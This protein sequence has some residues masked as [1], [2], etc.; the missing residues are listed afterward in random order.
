MRTPWVR[1]M[2][3]ALDDLETWKV[4]NMK[5]SQTAWTDGVIVNYILKRIDLDPCGIIAMFAKESAADEFVEEKF[6]PAVNATPRMAGKIEVNT[7]RKAGN[8]KLFKKYPGGFLKLV[9][10]NSPSSV[11]S[12]SAPVSIV[13]E[14]DDANTNVKGQGDTIKLLEDRSKTY[15]DRLVIYGGTPTIEGLSAIQDAYKSSDQRMYF[16]PC[17]ACGES[18]VLDWTNVKWDDD[19][20]IT[21][22]VYGHA[23]P[24][25]AFY[26]CPACGVIWDDD[27]KNANV[28]AAES[29]DG[30]GWIATVE[31]RGIA[32]FGYI[33]EL[34][35]PFDASRFKYLVERY[36]EAEN[37]EKQGDD[38]DM[39]AFVNTCLGKPYE[40]KNDNLNAEG[41]ETRAEDYE[42]ML[43]QQGG[44]VVTAGVDVQHDRFA[45]ILRA[46]GRG[47]ESW[48]VYWGE[49]FGVVTDKKD[50]V[51]TELERLLFM[52]PI[53]HVDGFN[54]NVSALSIDTSDGTTS[55][56]VYD[57]VRRMKRKYARIKTIP[58]KGSSDQADKEIF[59][60]PRISVDHRTPTKASRYGLRIFMVG[61]NKA[62]DL[63]TGR[64]QLTGAGPGRVHFYK[65]VRADYYAQITSEVKAPS[66]RLRGRMVWQKKSGVR[67][68][69]FDCE[70]Y[71][72]HAARHERVHLMTPA[73]WDDLEH[74][75]KQEDLFSQASVAES[76]T[77]M[78][79]DNTETLS[80]ITESGDPWLS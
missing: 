5:A 27:Q 3:A 8:K 12:T 17:H 43:V 22:E 44:L 40:Y 19:P 75:L 71:T 37:K 24:E 14:P 25:T 67:N 49:I 13:E 39:I 68:E 79:D 31:F 15:A 6:A 51:W 47:E 52:T 35:A 4:V 32:G 28:Q 58:V 2:Q 59:S 78:S 74:R 45:I 26:V 23:R 76:D 60:T 65:S 33:S 73:Q 36:L 80:S 11:K 69:A 20:T 57:W 61:T 72:L 34:Y 21:H 54:L 50:P 62:K 29:I 18:H 56:M 10:S 53:P 64:L 63:F 42:E 7:T 55:D 48:L 38:T 9:G 16:I 1:G 41:L 46:W 30:A 70:N 77:D 66:R